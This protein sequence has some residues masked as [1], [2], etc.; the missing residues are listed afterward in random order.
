M[1]K[2]DNINKIHFI[3]LSEESGGFA[4]G[5]VGLS[6]VSFTCTLKPNFGIFLTSTLIYAFIVSVYSQRATLNRRSGSLSTVH[7]LALA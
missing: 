3:S 1:D 2:L 4:G 5:A 6:K 7:R